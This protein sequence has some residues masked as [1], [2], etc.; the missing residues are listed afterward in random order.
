MAQLPKPEYVPGRLLVHPSEEFTDSG[1]QQLLLAH[2]A[3]LHYKIDG[4]NILVLDVPDTALDA[5]ATALAKTRVFSFVERDQIAHA[6]AVPNDTNFA[7]QW[8]LHKIQAPAAW[9]LARGSSSTPVAI[10]DSGADTTHPDLEGK[11]V[12]GWNFLNGTSDISDVQGHGTAVAGVLAAATNNL[13]GIAGVT[14]ANPIM[15]LVVLDANGNASYSNIASA[16]NYAADHGVRIINVSVGG[17]GAS[18]TLQSAVDYAWTK[19]AVVIAAVGSYT[20]ST[21]VY[22]AACNHVI[23]VTATD[24]SDTITSYSNHG[25][26]VGLSA[27]GEDLLTTSKGG[28]YGYWAGTSLATP[29]VSGVAALALSVNPSLTSSTLVSILENNADDLGAAGFDT[30]YGWGRVNAYKAVQAAKSAGDATAPTVAIIAPLA[31]A[32]VSGTV[33]VKGAA[34]DNVGVT[35]VELYVDGSLYSTGTVSAF[36]FSWNSSGKPNG[37]HSLSVKAYDAAGNARVASVSVNVLNS[38][39]TTALNVAISA[40]IAGVT[41]SGTVAV[42]GTAS[43]NVGVTKVELFVNGSLYASGTVSAYSFSWNSL[44]KANGA[45]TLMVKAYDAAGNTRSASITVNV[46]NGTAD[47]TAPTVAI[48]SPLAGSAVSGK[49]AVIGNS[50]D[51]VGVT[52]VE[53]Y[54]D[55]TLYTSVAAAAFSFSWDSTVHANGS[56]TLMVKAYDAAGNNRSTSVNVSVTNT[57]GTILWSAGLETGSTSEWYYPSTGHFGDYGGGEYN[58]GIASTAASTA[59]AHTGRWSAKMTVTTPSSPTSGTRMFRWME[60]RANRDLYYSVWVYIPTYYTLTG[61]PATGHYWNLFQFKSRTSDGSRIDPVW[62]FYIDDDLPGKYYLQAGWGWGGVTLAGPHMGD[63]VSGKFYM[64]RIAP[65]PIGQWVH[66]EAFLHQSNSYDG[67][68]ILWQDGVKL[69]DFPNVVTSYNNCNYNSW[70]AANEWSVN[71]YSDG[72]LPNPATIYIDDAKI[73][74]GLVP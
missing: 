63:P 35:K 14:W 51:N 22:P 61:N 37:P 7:S 49:V 71:L 29:V 34:S 26:F 44:T 9:D 16:I 12:A 23:A 45:Y 69:F 18:T 50:S 32:T 10:L 58:S 56:H 33:A 65:L 53:L 43:D 42:K 19:G 39:D 70:C 38:T 24:A 20:S 17:I 8:H 67:R 41:V 30:Y 47:T 74:T 11:L 60:A 64:Q 5:I 57:G 62:A 72:L 40:P 13:T 59:V 46:A 2:G 55:G 1:I 25:S 66:L 6:A 21:M 15:P 27:P 54:A 4:I 73:A 36:N 52:K 31:G 28:G 3:K 48:S 68:L